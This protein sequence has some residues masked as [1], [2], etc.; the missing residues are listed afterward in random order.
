MDYLCAPS[1]IFC[2]TSEHDDLIQ[3]ALHMIECGIRRESIPS[4]DP[5]HDTKTRRR[6]GRRSARHGGKGPGGLGGRGGSPRRLGRGA[7]PSAAAPQVHTCSSIRT[8]ASM[9]SVTCGPA[10][11]CSTQPSLQRTGS[12]APRPG[13]RG[14]LALA[15]SGD[16]HRCRPIGCYQA[17][18]RLAAQ[19]RRDR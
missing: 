7:R 17:A 19:Y 10:T 16:P 4:C 9:T 18:D 6:E 14:P 15:R 12:C 8:L 13:A 11:R 1:V 2:L 3:A 5:L